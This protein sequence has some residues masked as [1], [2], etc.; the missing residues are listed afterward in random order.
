[1]LTFEEY[2]RIGNFSN[3]G[4]AELLADCGYN[5]LINVPNKLDLI[6]FSDTPQGKPCGVSQVYEGPAEKN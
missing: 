5:S 2:K 1:M 6:A 3:K 4:R